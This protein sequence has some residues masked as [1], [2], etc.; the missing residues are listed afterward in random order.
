MKA[1]ILA[2][3]RSTR[4]YPITLSMPKCLLKVGE[5]TIIE[6][7]IDNLTEIGIKDILVVTGY[8]KEEIEGFLKD[9]V[10]Y[11]FFPDFAK[12]N[13]LH[14]LYSIRDELD[15]DFICLFSDVLLGKEPLMELMNNDDDFCLLVHNKEVL[16][17]TM[18]VK[19]KNGSV[20]DIGGH[21]PP[22]E[23][24]ANFIG[25]AKF[26]KK[27]A[28]LLAEEM[29]GMIK[30]ENHIND[31]YTMALPGL[32][33]KGYKI[34]FI[35]MDDKPWIEIDTKDDLDRARGMELK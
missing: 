29:E 26:S 23:G 11:A 32:A 20:Y 1:I 7:Q 16:E 14:T 13:N 31:Y 33:E 27:A 8:L 19:I 5:K 18:R 28:K 35:N 9:R 15:S 2:A 24:E 30:G 25:V 34:S 6:R 22:E 3:G 4:L 10:R 12:T 21:I 17:G